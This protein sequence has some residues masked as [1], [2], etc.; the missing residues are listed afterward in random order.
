M[1]ELTT[2]TVVNHRH[3]LND[4]CILERP[5][6]RGAYYPDQPVDLSNFVR[7]LR[8]QFPRLERLTLIGAVLD[9]RIVRQQLTERLMIMFGEQ[10]TQLQLHFVEHPNRRRSVWKEG[11]RKSRRLQNLPPI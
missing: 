7:R 3:L 4:F 11:P 10:L 9:H 8:F 6:E 1:P 2:L 5:F